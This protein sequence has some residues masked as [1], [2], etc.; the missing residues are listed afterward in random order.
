[1][2]DG[3]E[4]KRVTAYLHNATV[5]EALQVL[6]SVKGLTYQGRGGGGYILSLRKATEPRFYPLKNLSLTVN[7][8]TGEVNEAWIVTVVREAIGSP[9]KVALVPTNN[10][11]MVIADPESEALVETIISEIDRPKQ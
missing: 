5:R 9:A 4:S 3:I 11:V 1:V 8:N 2:L 10:S 6:L 7:P